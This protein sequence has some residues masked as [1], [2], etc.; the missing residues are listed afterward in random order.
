MTLWTV[1]HQ[2]PLSMKF[3]KQEYWSQLPSPPPGDLLD[4]QMEPESLASS[5]LASGF[6]TAEPPGKPQLHGAKFKNLD[7][8]KA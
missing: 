6:F 7:G 5:A 2:D 3:L 4:P 8:K 1:A